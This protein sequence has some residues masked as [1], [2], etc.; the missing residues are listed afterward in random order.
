MFERFKRLW[1]LSE[2][3]VGA[4][5]DEYKIP[6]TQIITLVKKPKQDAVFIPKVSIDPVKNI[7]E[8]QI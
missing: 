3:E 6:G 4:P 2:Y 5:Q 7:T 8:E 1:K